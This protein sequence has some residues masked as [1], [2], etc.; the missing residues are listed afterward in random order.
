MWRLVLIASALLS[1]CSSPPPRERPSG[2]L[3]RS[4]SPESP[5]RRA[6]ADRPHPSDEDHHPL[7]PDRFGIGG[8]MARRRTA[9]AG[10]HSHR[11]LAM[12]SF[13]HP[14]CA[15][16]TAEQRRT[17]PILAQRWTRREVPGG[18]ELTGAAV[19]AGRAAALRWHFLCHLA[20]G[21]TAGEQG[22]CPLHVRGARVATV[23]EGQRV[24]VRI[25]TDDAGQVSE[26]R[27][28]ARGLLP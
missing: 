8:E 24:R 16:L 4:G 14:A 3:V 5:S 1:G 20:F 11:G 21:Q 13:S 6:S 17:C 2:S 26:L 18:V 28:R 7:Q 23:V 19:S 22:G 15:A 25:V 9:H 27:R 12:E 10:E